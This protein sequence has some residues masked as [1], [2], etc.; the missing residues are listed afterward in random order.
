MPLAYKGLQV[1]MNLCVVSK[2]CFDFARKCC[3]TEEQYAIE[4]S[5]QTIMEVFCSQRNMLRCLTNASTIC[6]NDSAC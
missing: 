2:T 5:K 4:G 3:A 6:A 1:G